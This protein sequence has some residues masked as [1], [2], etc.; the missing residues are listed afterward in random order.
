MWRK[1]E[2][3][4]CHSS[5]CQREFK[6]Q[7]QKLLR[8]CLHI[9]LHFCWYNSLSHVCTYCFK[10]CY[11]LS[12]CSFALYPI[13]SPFYKEETMYRVIIN[14]FCGHSHSKSEKIKE[15]TFSHKGEVCRLEGQTYTISFVQM[16][17]NQLS[18]F[19]NLLLLVF[20]SCMNIWLWKK[21]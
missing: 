5:L 8:F 2:F 21:F 6:Q 12:L 16:K 19:R 7:Q 4:F 17:T 10:N 14:W 15:D 18:R 13:L 3:S 9:L 1:C 11:F 20:V